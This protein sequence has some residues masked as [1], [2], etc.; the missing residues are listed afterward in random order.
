M[1][2]HECRHPASR[3]N[4]R[5]PARHTRV[6]AALPLQPSSPSAA[7][8][9]SEHVVVCRAKQRRSRTYS[10]RLTAA[11]AVGACVAATAIAAAAAAVAIA[12]ASAAAVAAAAA[13]AAACAAVAAAG[14]LRSTQRICGGKCHRRR[15]KRQHQRQQR[16]SGHRSAGAHTRDR[17][18][19]S[20][21][22]QAPSQR[23][24][25]VCIQAI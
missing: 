4:V 20:R 22:A 15:R 14:C 12:A 6:A 2:D 9:R 13:I 23:L 25:V 21:G 17:R 1:L 16:Q 18:R 3:P 19:S 10:C 11:A 7:Q 24:A 5:V 8:Q